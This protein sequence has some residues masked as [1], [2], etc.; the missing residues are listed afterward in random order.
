MGY[1]VIASK[2]A[3]TDIDETIGYISIQLGNQK[4]ARD[5]LSKLRK[6]Y[7]IIA[8]NPFLYPI[9]RNPVFET[10]GYRWFPVGNYMVFYTIDEQAGEVRIAR[11]I[12]GRRNLKPLL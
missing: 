7:E 10:K 12:Y 4:A 3:E 2:H 8:D 5:F 1:K 6:H 9:A 11:V